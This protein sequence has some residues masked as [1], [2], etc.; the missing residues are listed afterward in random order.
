ML[1]EALFVIL[2][3]EWKYSVKQDLESTLSEMYAHRMC[4]NANVVPDATDNADKRFIRKQTF[5][6]PI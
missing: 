5:D 3:S 1:G 6:G 4:S 2:E